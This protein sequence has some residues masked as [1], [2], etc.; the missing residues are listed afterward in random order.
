MKVTY[1]VASSLDGFIAAEDGSVAWLD[2]L[3]IAMEDTGYD[4][5]YAT[6]DA[7][8]MGRGTYEMIHSFGTWPYGDKPTWVCTNGE[9]EPME[10]ANIQ[11][12]KLPDEVAAEAGKTRINHLWLVGGGKL[13]ASFLDAGLLTD[14]S[15][16][17]MPVMLGKGIRLFGPMKKPLKF[18]LLQCDNKKAGFIQLEY[19]VKR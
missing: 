16:S 19:S 13:A 10:G 1:Y 7:L 14:I 11:K 12:G 6:V 3:G 15:I 17:Q 4:A 9:I 5:F 18:E 8:V 2:E